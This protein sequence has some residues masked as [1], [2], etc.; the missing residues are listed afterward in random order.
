MRSSCWLLFERDDKINVVPQVKGAGCEIII[1]IGAD[2]RLEMTNVQM[3]D[4]GMKIQSVV[5]AINRENHLSI[6]QD[7]AA[8]KEP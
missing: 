5:N 4:L 1:N 6:E 2:S 3:L 8:R 7:L